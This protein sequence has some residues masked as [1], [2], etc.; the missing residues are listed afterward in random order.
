MLRTKYL[1]A[2]PI[3]SASE[4][5]HNFQVRVATLC[6]GTETPVALAA[7]VCDR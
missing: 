4:G 5:I 1:L 6:I 2:H 3:Y 7:L